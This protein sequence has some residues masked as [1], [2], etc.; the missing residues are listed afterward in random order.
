MNSYEGLKDLLILKEL[1]E[2]SFVSAEKKGIRISRETTSG[3]K[4]PFH[5]VL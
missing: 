3:S 4:S 5:S 1:R 2:H